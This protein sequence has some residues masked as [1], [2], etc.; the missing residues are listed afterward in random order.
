M[1]ARQSRPDQQKVCI[2]TAGA[3][4]MHCILDRDNQDTPHTLHSVVWFP[5]FC[6]W[7][8]AARSPARYVLHIPVPGS[9]SHPVDDLVPFSSILRQGHPF[10][11]EAPGAART[12]TRTLA[13]SMCAC[14]SMS[15]QVFAQVR[16]LP[17][18]VP[19]P[20]HSRF[21]HRLLSVYADTS[22][23]CPHSMLS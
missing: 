4:L 19:L 10:Q 20:L 9:S 5:G 6:W 18:L 21:L 11:V 8:S 15:V 16:I 1:F 23:G 3:Q 14:L 12:P 2:G 13:V 22:L 17:R 7:A